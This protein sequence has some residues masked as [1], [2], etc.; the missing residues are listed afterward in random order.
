MYILYI[1]YMYVVYIY[2]YYNYCLWLNPASPDRVVSNATN[3]IVYDC[4][5]QCMSPAVLYFPKV[6]RIFCQKIM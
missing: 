4:I 1:L 2:V 5:V 6:E 3:I